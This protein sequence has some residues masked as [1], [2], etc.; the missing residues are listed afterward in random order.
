MKFTDG[1]WQLRSGVTALYAREAYDIVASEREI[2]VTA[3]TKEITTRADT[4]NCP[5][6]TVTLGSPLT[7][8]VSVAIEH[9]KAATGARG[10]DFQVDEAHSPLISV[11][12][13]G[14]RLTSGDLTV[15]V[16]QGAPWN[17][18]FDARW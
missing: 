3:P 1:F 9:W 13:D 11:D 15:T 18:S 2:V 7:N 8:V 6:L 12:E 17:L 4:L 14:G 10:F 5:T 16:R